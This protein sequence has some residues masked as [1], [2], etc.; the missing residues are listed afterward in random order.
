[1][2]NDLVILLHGIL[3]NKLDMLPLSKFLEKHGYDTLNILYP[4]RKR[5]LEDLTDYVHEKITASPLYSPDKTLNFVTHSMGGLI[6]RYYIATHNPKNLGKVVMLS[7]PNTGSDF[8]DYLT[9]HKILAKPYRAVFGPAGAQLV[10]QYDHI[11]E[12]VTYPLGIIAG[13]KSINPLALIAMPSARVGPHDGIVPVARTHIDGQA[14]HITLPVNH[15]F[16]M[17]DKRVMAQV[18]EFLGNGR[19]KN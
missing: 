3:R 1:M 2:A 6:A 16:M 15:T 12:A 4:S 10:T 11:D 13:N 14:D 8:A 9:Q 5:S 17:F 18:L 7:P 19:F